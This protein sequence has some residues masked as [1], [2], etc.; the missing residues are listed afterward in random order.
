MNGSHEGAED[1]VTLEVVDG[2]G[3]VTLN[4]PDRLNAV[5]HTIRAAYP[6]RMAEAAAREDVRAIVLTGA[7]RGFCAGADVKVLGNLGT[8]TRGTMPGRDYLVARTVAKP[9]IAAVNGACAGLGL[10]FALSCDV[11]FAAATATFDTGFA[12]R[13]LV[14]EQGTAWLLA[15]S[16]GP[17]RALDLLYDGRTLSG[18]EAHR[19]GLVDHLHSG[20]GVL[21]AAVA[22]ARDVAASKS[23][24][25]LGVMKWQVQRAMETSLWQALDD[26]D[27]LTRRSLAGRD[28]L[29]HGATLRRDERADYPPLRDGRLGD[30]SPVHLIEPHRPTPES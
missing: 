6:A 1:A 13:G 27:E 30:E 23:P 16:V 5:D 11:R 24:M 3:I 12:R 19:I 8:G 14:A 9:V 18:T 15:R 4:R 22:Y 2:V 26:A 28:F 25:S 29:Q 17:S 20:D 21:A 7:G 10:V